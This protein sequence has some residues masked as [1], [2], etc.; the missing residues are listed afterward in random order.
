MKKLSPEELSDLLS[1][2]EDAVVEKT[3]KPKT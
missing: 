3:E 2:E 1:G